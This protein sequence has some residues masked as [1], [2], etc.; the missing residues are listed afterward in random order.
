MATT[1]PNNAPPAA[2]SAA[3]IVEL[4]A[5]AGELARND[6][7]V[8]PRE[9]MN[10]ELIREEKARVC[11][12]NGITM[13]TAAEVLLANAERKK[14]NHRRTLSTSIVS[15]SQTPRPTAVCAH[16]IVALT[17]KD[18]RRAR[19]H[20]FQHSIGINDADNGVFLPAHQA[21]MPGYPL[22]AHHKPKHSPEYHYA[23]FLRVLRGKDQAGCRGQL[24]GIK[25]SLLAGTMSL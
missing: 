20:I 13:P 1:L 24:R 18:A 15:A 17:D 14:Y 25:G 4:A 11:Y 12:K 19:I 22:A 2:P 21:G 7:S 3:E 8:N 16:H 9:L 6:S 5:T 10:A 23:V